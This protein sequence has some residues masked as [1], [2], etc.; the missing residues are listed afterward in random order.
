MSTGIAARE[1]RIQVDK[2]DE[3]ARRE[4]VDSKER[5]KRG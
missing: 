1:K 5:N 4:V 3:K 2:A